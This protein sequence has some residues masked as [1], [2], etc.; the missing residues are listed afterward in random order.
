MH[1][2]GELDVPVLTASVADEAELHEL[3]LAEYGRP[4]DLRRGPLLRA[5]LVR[6]REDEHVLLLGAHH[7]VIDG[8]SMG[9]LLK[10]LA[11]LYS[12]R[13]TGVPAELPALTVQYPDFAVWQRNRLATG[14]VDDQLDYWKRQLAGVP[15]LG[16]ATDR[17]RPPVY[18][19][20]G[21]VLDFTVPAD[22]TGALTALA[23][24]RQT[25]LFAVLVAAC[26]VL[27]ARWSNQDDIAVGSVV[28]GRNRPELHNLV[29]FFVNT[30]VLRSTVDENRS[31]GEFL[32]TVRDVALDAV[33]HDEAPFEQVLDALHVQREVSR[34]PL[35]DVMVLLHDAPTG[36]PEFAG[37]TAAAVDLARD[38]ANFDLTYEFQLRDDVLIGSV[39]YNTHLYDEATVRRMAGHLTTLL[40]AVASAPNRPLAE[41]DMLDAAERTRL[42]TGWHGV[43][44]PSAER[45]FPAIF[46]D[47]A[48]T[49]PNATALVCGE[50]SYTFAE[51]DA[52]A[53]Q[54]AHHLIASGVGP[55]RVVALHLPR[56]AETIAAILAVWK[57]G[58]VYLPIDPGLPADRIALLLADARPTVVVS[59]GCG[60]P[61]NTPHLLLADLLTH[62]T[63]SNPITALTP[64]NTAYL[65][66][67]SGSTGTPK[68]VAVEHRNLTNLLTA[69]QAGLLRDA[70]GRLRVALTAA[71]SFDTSLE[72]PVLMAA[73]HEL[74]LID[75]TV[76]HDPAALVD[77]ITTRRIDF[78]DLTPTFLA[79]LLPAGLLTDPRHRPAILMLG[80]EALSE[81]LR[82]TLAAAPDTT[83]HNF[84]GPTESTVDAVACRIDADGGP[85]IG[86]PLANVRAYVLDG[87]LRPV[88]VGVPGQLHLA[89][90]QLARGYHDRP[91]LTADRFVADPYGPAGSRMYATGDLVRRRADGQLD[92]LGRTDQ[93]IKVHGHRIEP[94]E[95]ETVLQAH[96]AVDVAVVDAHSDGTRTRLVAYLVG[97]ALPSTAD[98]R[99]YLGDRLPDY[100]VPA[101]FVPLAELP[102]TSSG[103]LD[104][105][106]LP[107]PQFGT[108]TEQIAPST[109]TETVLAEIWAKALGL[110]RVGV[111]DN[112]FELGGDSILSIEIVSK[113]RQRGLLL[114]ARDMFRYQTIADLAATV[115]RTTTDELDRQPVLE[116]APLGP[117]QRWFF[118]TYGALG[119]FS[120]SMLLA[121]DPDLDRTALRAALTA[122][123]GTHEALRTRFVQVAGEW[124]QEVTPAT[125]V[126]L[127]IVDADRLANAALAAQ[128]SL[129]PTTG[130]VF[131]AVLDDSGRLFLTAHHLVVD[132]VSW[133]I[134][135]GD[136][137]TAYRQALAGEPVVLPPVGTPFGRW[138]QRLAEHDEPE[139]VVLDADGAL[140]VDR[141]GANTY[142]SNRKVTVRLSASDTEALLRDVPSV[143][144]TRIDDV[145]LTALGRVLSDWTG[146]DR[147]LVEMEGHGR[148]ALPANVE[149]SRTV[150][151]FTDMYPVAV[152]VPAGQGWG[153]ALKTTKE[154]RRGIAAQ[155][156]ISLNYHGQWHESTGE[157]LIRAQLP[158][159][160]TDIAPTAPRTTLIDITGF[161]DGDELELTWFYS[162]QAHDEATVRGLADR[163]LDALRGI[164]E[165][166]ADPAAGG[167]TPSDFPLARLDQATVD[168]LVGDGRTV[169]DIYP[170]TGLQAGMLFHSLV[171][172]GGSVYTDQ[173]CLRLSGVE[174][175]D[176]IGPAWQRVVDR[177]PALR[178]AMRWREVPEPVQIVW[179]AVELPVTTHDW[180][181]PDWEARLTEFLAEDLGA[182]MD[183]GQAPLARLAVATLPGDEVFVVFTSH[184]LLL[185]GWSLGQVFADM[186]QEYAA[187][188]AGRTVEPVARRPFREFLDWLAAQD[189]EQAI[190]YWRQVLGGFDTPTPLPF[191]RRPAPEHRAE[192]AAAVDVDLSVV[193]TGALREM[194]RQHGLTVNTLVQGAWALL[195]SRYGGGDDVVFGT[196]VSGRPADLPGAEHMIGMFINTVPTRA[197]VPSGARVADWLRAVQDAQAEARRFDF[198]PV[199]RTRACSAVPE[200]TNLFDSMVVFEN[201][202]FDENAVLDAGLRVREVRATETTNFP[203]S[204]RVHADERLHLHLAYD[205]ALFDEP[206][207]ASM[208]GHLARLL[209][210]LA[211]EPERTLASVPML[212]PIEEHRLLVE[213]NGD[214]TS[215][216]T[217][218]VPARFERQA[219]ASPDAIAVGTLTYA[220]LNTRANRLAHRLI[221]AGAGPERLVALVLPRSVELVVAVLAVLKTGAAYLPLDPDYPAERISG[222]ITD[223]NPVAV[224]RSIP[225]T[226]G[227][228]GTNPTDAD[229]IASLDPRHP[230]Y[231][232]Y[233]SGSTGRPK[234]VLIPHEN[235]LRLFDSTAHWFGFADTDVW[236]LFH[237]YAF[238]FSVW[239]LWGPLL[240][241]GRLVVVP[242]TVSRSPGDFLRLLVNERVTVLNQTPS[243]FYQL[244]AADQGEPSCL[245]YV[246]FG[247]EALD[248]RR[249]GEWYAR[250]AEDAPRLVNMY[251][252]TETT[253]H[254]T[255]LP[256]DAASAPG[257]IGVPIPDLRAYVLDRDLRPV[258]VG[259]PGE[260]FVAGA[261]L[262][263]GYLG[264]PGLTAD[265]FVADPFGSPGTRM[266][267]TGDVVRW[268]GHGVLEFGGRA[269][270]QVKIRGFRIEPGEIEAALLAQPEIG[271]AVVL[272][273]QDGNGEQRLIGYLVAAE[274]HD[275]DQRRVR[276]ALADVL[277]V[278][279]MPAALV[280]VPEFPLTSNGKLDVRA[281][282]EPD[283]ALPVGNRVAPRTETE[284]VIATAWAELLGVASVGAEDNF[285]E[286]G[287]DSI[288]SIRLA[289]KLRAALGV[290]VSPRTTFTHLT[291]ATQAEAVTG[292]PAPTAIARTAHA[293]PAPLSFAQQR[294]WFLDQFE[295]GSTEYLT[296]WGVRLS[297]PLD[298]AALN[299]ALNALVVRHG[300]LRTT[301]DDK[302]QVVHE[303]ESVEI[304]VEEGDLR[305]ILAEENST[306]FDLRTG[307]LWRVRLIRLGDDEHALSIAMHHIITDGWSMGV[308]IDELSAAYRGE[309]LPAPDMSYVDYT[310]W[311]RAQDLDGQLGYWREQLAGL[312]PLDLATDRPR[313]SVQTT[314]GAVVEFTLPARRLAGAGRTQRRQPVHRVGRGVH[315]VAA[316][317]ERPVRPGRRHGGV[318]SATGRTGRVDRHVRQHGRVAVARGRCRVVHRAPCCRARH[319][320]RRARTPGRAVRTARRRARAGARHQQDPAVPGHGGVAER[321]QPGARPARRE[322]WPIFRCPSRPPASTSASTSSNRATAWRRGSSTTR[323][324]SRRPRSSGWP[325]TCSPCAPPSPRHRADRWPRWICCPRPNGTSCCTSGPP[326]PSTCRT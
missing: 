197:S 43:D 219:A 109:E 296:W 166:C 174:R 209:T 139:S 41:L 191:D 157:G 76:R 302:T 113:A 220:E 261:G 102:T 92:Y 185:D 153:D 27:F 78:L 226:S 131:A 31:F 37:L 255:Y 32:G 268:T 242:H 124:R 211:A 132:G 262:A 308:L 276:A 285:F 80:G 162:D 250:H 136:L 135:L 119:H 252:I 239:E 301:F 112:F 189:E 67:T 130:V 117:I 322:P 210:G 182:G 66:Y 151:W 306:P 258:P 49:T 79:Q 60:L 212:D 289:A 99:A 35:F 128:E 273:R 15:P 91:G 36:L 165:H 244:M 104:R 26:Q 230:A 217:D 12:E 198:V 141:H 177:N 214:R 222:T 149:L 90:A 194:A 282:P 291:V 238:D 83:S 201:Y 206:T 204:A 184:H 77:Y 314:N 45:T 307:P 284:R 121:L 88:P 2:P 311:Q 62:D 14:A 274:H 95:I 231:V 39:E 236:T 86:R 309:T 72:G 65:I 280:T 303:P 298:V 142:G 94:G 143:Y 164:V 74:H 249:L 21:A 235:V 115:E 293:G 5:S 145:L 221:A 16:L 213:W 271:Q 108:D 126:D 170:L 87:R 192:S 116:P 251:G 30:V 196:T 25:T 203:L 156:L 63:T 313:P 180:R 56:T 269:D 228:P 140:P 52:R 257:A 260:L 234:G 10:E 160:G 4:F 176:L 85:V 150:G 54:V 111:R 248:V 323:T 172:T 120:M 154:R 64:G 297:G 51:L 315:G 278:H 215:T 181:T 207:V 193:D 195:L 97:A 299:R 70:H 24:D 122:L 42:I 188:L 270:T 114:H 123:V 134:L 246:I 118:D 57:A 18:R 321:G 89:G 223:A 318:R 267:R 178:S 40:A 277:P 283:G 34:N 100:L 81:S 294:L 237:S 38:V 101:A 224:L 319:R 312:T 168:L 241:G 11:A 171:D 6:V 317:L 218:T 82:R 147:V 20:E 93:Q 50:T 137:E 300:S 71:L 272:A 7:I 58:G 159:F 205:P 279:M 133:R 326:P 227:S 225:D 247:G 84:Y 161:V 200:G 9:V 310:M 240:H 254:V 96:P 163:L 148:D 256:L 208:A 324:C 23:R 295:P 59:T 253:V 3:L 264:R 125:P 103:K 275:V 265:R 325:S 22:V 61:P 167:R 68:G 199:S 229:R 98:L 8:W 55:E 259:V 292:E 17:P 53:N 320:A 129:D 304:R 232:I 286:L 216:V 13:V 202:P 127:R 106:A 110:D 1:A 138:A 107:E 44:V 233:T 245:R 243:A 33:A 69:H 146:R 266:Y 183:L 305:R 73:G 173:A 28:S 263:R 29:G 169:E 144:R 316:A 155:P 186:C 105:R 158:G 19:T 281:L 288:A 152:G 48:A 179:S 287:G 75:D 175:P 190:A 47:Q 46:Q 187:L 290:E